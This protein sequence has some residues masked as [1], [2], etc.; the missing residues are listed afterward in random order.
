[1]RD[2]GRPR[3][4]AHRDVLRDTLRSL[5]ALIREV[6]AVKPPAPEEA[7]A[8]AA[9]S[10]PSPSP[11]AAASEG[12]SAPRDIAAPAPEP[13]APSPGDPGALWIYDEMDGTPGAGGDTDPAEEPAATGAA[14]GEPR[15]GP[16]TETP[17]ATGGQGAGAGEGGPPPQPGTT[18]D[19]VTTEVMGTPSEPPADPLDDVPILEEVAIIHQGPGRHSKAV[20]PAEPHR[21]APQGAPEPDSP[22]PDP[23]FLAGVVDYINAHLDRL[24]GRTLEQDE[25]NALKGMLESFLHRWSARQGGDR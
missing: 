8:P 25:A 22:F 21:E 13:E 10:P 11:E 1:M 14:D 24:L 2:K 12:V 3:Q 15:S 4:P 9:E 19:W 17:P 20:T 6:D 5:E 23:A 7:A 18:V 16:A